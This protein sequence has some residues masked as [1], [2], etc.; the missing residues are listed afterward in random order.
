MGLPHR[1]GTS[2]GDIAFDVM[3]DGAPVVLVHGTPSRAAAWRDVAAALST[4]HRVYVYDLAGFGQSERHVGQD[5]S[6]V[7]HGEVLAELTRAWQLE[8]PAVVG[9]DIGC[10][11]ALRAHLVE[12]IAI[13]RLALIDAVV[14]RPWITERTRRMQQD[15]SRYPRLPDA[16]LASVIREHLNSA[17]CRR[18][19]DDL[20]DLL[21]DQ[22]AG[23]EGQ[24]LYLR[25]IHCLDEADTDPVEERL[26]TLAV[27][28]LIVWGGKDAWLPVSTSHRIAAAV[29]SPPPTIQRRGTLFNARPT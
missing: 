10:A 20:F 1:M 28:V 7:V 26:A 4:E 2:H 5:V 9:H 21:F 24:A 11:T 3:G 23:A 25:N 13:E 29:G 14:L 8:A 27:P 19:P 15:R 12:G 16:D 22:W 6:L 17:T 18:L